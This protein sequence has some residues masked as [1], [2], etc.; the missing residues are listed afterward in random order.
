MMQRALADVTLVRVDV[1]A[2][3]DDLHAMRVETQSVPWFY[4]LDDSGRPTDAIN[5]DEWD[6]NIPENMAPVL[7]KFV[8][9]TLAARR[10]RGLQR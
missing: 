10:A 6:E 9:G 1:D 3:E 4:K 7:A 5:A 8:R 2:F